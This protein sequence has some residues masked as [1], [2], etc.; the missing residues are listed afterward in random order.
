MPASNMTWSACGAAS[1][2][3]A[4]APAP[5]KIVQSVFMAHRVAI[6]APPEICCNRVTCPKDAVDVHSHWMG[7]ATRT[8]LAERI[9]HAPELLSQR[10]E[11]LCNDAPDQF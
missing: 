2:A 4:R 1:C 3:Q 9:G 11:M 6:V 7:F 5:S 8:L 10:V